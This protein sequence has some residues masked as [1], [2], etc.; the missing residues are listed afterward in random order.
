MQLQ[1]EKLATEVEVKNSKLMFSSVQMAHKNE[2]LTEVKKDLIDLQKTPEKN[3]RSLVRK[4]D[5]ELKNE[6]Y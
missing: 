3:T 2:I 4:L 5:S 6:D 1:N